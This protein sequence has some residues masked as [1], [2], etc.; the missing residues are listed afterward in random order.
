MNKL[1]TGEKIGVGVMVGLGGLVLIVLILALSVSVFAGLAYL[2]M[3]IILPLFDVN[4]Q[5]TWTQ[6]FG[7]GGAIVIIRAL[8][9]S[10]LSVNISK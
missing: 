3:N 9:S 7:A 2:L 6:C 8:L 4:Y 10:V 1:S 5:L